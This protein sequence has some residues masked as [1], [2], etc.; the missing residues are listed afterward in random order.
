VAYGARIRCVS[1]AEAGKREVVG[2]WRK[3]EGLAPA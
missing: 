1:G 3:H 2:G